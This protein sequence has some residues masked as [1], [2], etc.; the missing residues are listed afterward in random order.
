[1]TYRRHHSAAL[2]H[3]A[4]VLTLVLTGLAPGFARERGPRIDVLC[5]ASP[6]AVKLGQEQVLVYELHITNFDT[7]PLTFKQLEVFGDD[8]SKAALLSL[9]DASLPKV[10]IHVGGAM[11]MGGARTKADDARII[12][13]GTRVIIYI[14]IGLPA[15]ASVPGRLLHRMT[16]SVPNTSTDA[17]LPA[18]EVPVRRSE[19]PTLAPPF[20]GGT[21]LAGGGPAND[22]AHRRSIFA[23]D[24]HIGTPKPAPAHDFAVSR[25]RRR[26]SGQEAVASR[27]KRSKEYAMK[28][29][30]LSSLIA[31]AAFTLILF[32]ANLAAQQAGKFPHYTVTDLGTLGGTFSEA[33]GINNNG[34]LAGNSAIPGDVAIHATLWR[35]GAITD[36]GT[37]G[38]PNSIAPEAEPQPNERGEVAG[39]SD[40]TIADPNGEDF[41]GFGTHL[42]CLPFVWRKGSLT[43]LPTLGGYNGIA[44]EINNRGQVTGTA[45]NAT[46]DPN[47]TAFALEAKPVIWEK[48]NITELS[49]VPGDLD[50]FAQGINDRGQAVG[51]STNCPSE[52]FVFPSHAVLWTGGPKKVEIDLGN[53]GST[54]FNVAFGINDR[55]QV[56]GQSGLPGNAAFHAFL[57]QG[58]KMSDLGTLPGDVVSWAET[59]NSKG[60]AVGTSFDANNNTHPF[61]WQDGAMTNLNTLISPNSPWLLLEALGNNNRGQIVGFGLRT[62]TGEAHAFVATPCDDDHPDIEGCDYSMVE[63]AE[64]SSDT[65]AARVPQSTQLSKE[66][67]ARMMGASRNPFLRRY[68]LPGL[69]PAPSN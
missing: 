47:C 41:C 31:L 4:L 60:Q 35:Y 25:H 51:I 44:L 37:L 39:A 49:T 57:W 61:I 19:V 54:F 26:R 27:Q 30:K 17:I 8:Q 66:A 21:W 34:S 58:G 18:L 2:V 22:S 40:T 68:R 63:A 46:Q 67:I 12:L 55:G 9:T 52:L 3:A 6:I 65:S 7:V 24:G 28:F 42:I 15:G 69:R 59:I 38:G 43:A 32:P 64:V 50:G 48:G 14:W 5:P 53:L 33:V 13:P 36:L 45:E 20:H 1:M 56:V 16:F 62:D 29:R 10:M 23:I 11:V